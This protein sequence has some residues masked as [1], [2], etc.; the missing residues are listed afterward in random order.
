MTRSFGGI[1]RG[2]VAAAIVTALALPAG[3]LAATIQGTPGNDILLG[4]SAADTISGLA[5]N[6][7]LYGAGGADVLDGDG[8]TDALFGGSGGDTLAGGADADALVGGPGADALDGGAGDD[9][10]FAAGDRTPDTVAC[11]DGNDR[12]WVGPTDVVD[13]SCEIIVRLAY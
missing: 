5:G 9:A 13:S 1:R 3:V 7:L 11:G 2:I 6:D 4:T 8:G 12:A 10:I